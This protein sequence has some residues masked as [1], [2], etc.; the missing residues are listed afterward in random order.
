MLDYHVDRARNIVTTRAAGR[1]SV[2]DLTGHFVRLMR[3]PAFSPDLNAL[4]IVADVDAVP[5]PVGV[6]ALAPLVRA[7]SK[8][9]AGVKWALVLPNR[10]TRDF[11]ES[12]LEQVKLTSVAARCFLSESAALQWLGTPPAPLKPVQ[13]GAAEST[14]TSAR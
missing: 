14:A 11:A 12:A 7:W 4:I 10:A 5:G 3:D 9:R 2:G 13:D 6:G 1:V 8:R